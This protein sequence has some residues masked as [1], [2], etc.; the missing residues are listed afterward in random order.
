MRV[1]SSATRTKN[2]PL[3]VAEGCTGHLQ[4]LAKK[5]LVHSNTMS[6]YILRK[7]GQG[8]L[9]ILSHCVHNSLISNSLLDIF[10]VVSGACCVLQEKC[11][12]GQVHRHFNEGVCLFLIAAIWLQ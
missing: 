9:I 12:A 7:S 2:A 4:P 5:T 6:K 11:K 1:P 3:L 8:V 10:P